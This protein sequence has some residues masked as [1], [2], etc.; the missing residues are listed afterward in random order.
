MDDV[1]PRAVPGGNNPPDALITEAA[2]RTETAN[3]WLSE[4]GD[5]E[6]WDAETADKANFFVG[7]IGATHGALDGRRLEEGR[8]FKAEQDKV[9]KD[10]LAL[11]TMAKAKLAD[12]RRKWLQRE[13]ARVQEARRKA[14]ANALAAREEAEAAARRAAKSKTPLEAEL[15][16]AKAQEAAEEAQQ[17]LEAAPEKAV[18]KGAFSAR[19]TG[20]R[21]SWSA[22]ITDLS[23][24]FR[25]YNAKKHPARTVLEAAIRTAIQAIAN[26]EAVARKTENAADFPPGVKFVKDRR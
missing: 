20:L 12:L 18:I 9:Y 13:D 6:K 25:H 3:R 21:D 14:E 26:H 19:A 11:L 17:K 2:E 10:P 7:Q 4:R 1:N 8:V 22:E 16:A 23:A 5:W 24:A 15:A